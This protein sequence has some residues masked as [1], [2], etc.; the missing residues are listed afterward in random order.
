MEQMKIDELGIF[1]CRD[2]AQ[3]AL[4]GWDKNLKDRLA[5]AKEDDEVAQFVKGSLSITKND[6]W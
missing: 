4:A 6:V 5:N 2:T 1:G 3:D